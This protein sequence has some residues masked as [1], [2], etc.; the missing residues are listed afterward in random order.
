MAPCQENTGV[1]SPEIFHKKGALLPQ[2]NQD[3]GMDHPEIIG[4]ILATPANGE[5]IEYDRGIVN[6]KN[7]QQKDEEKQDKNT[8]QRCGAPTRDDLTVFRVERSEEV[9]K[10]SS[11]C[12]E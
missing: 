4:I 8:H 7:N 6:L 2:K 1:I 9:A 3:I 12:H 5:G 11:L 10:T